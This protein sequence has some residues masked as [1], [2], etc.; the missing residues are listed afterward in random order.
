MRETDR[1]SIGQAQTPSVWPEPLRQHGKREMVLIFRSRITKNFYFLRQCFF[2]KFEVIVLRINVG[3]I[4]KLKKNPRKIQKPLEVP[5]P[6]WS[7][8]IRDLCIP[9]SPRCETC[10]LRRPDLLT[11]LG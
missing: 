8:D 2:S 4:Y 7:G 9:I 10:R 5:Q 3:G 11:A 1:V 6:S